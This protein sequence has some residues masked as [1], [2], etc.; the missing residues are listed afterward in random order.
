MPRD[1]L[2]GMTAAD[3]SELPPFVLGNPG[4]LRDRLVAATLS[5]EKTA[6][7]SLLAE[8][9]DEPLPEPGQRFRVIDSTDHDVGIVEV[10][11]IEVIALADATL[12]LAVA[13]G[14]GFASVAEW[15]T[16]H[17]DFWNDD[18]DVAELGITIDDDTQIV[19]EYFRVVAG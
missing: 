12:E 15:R 2:P 9:V 4:P 3:A 10:T 14:E 16:A 17:E 1:S 5:G 7:S 19:V 13:E 8:Y 18:D 6:T 11:S